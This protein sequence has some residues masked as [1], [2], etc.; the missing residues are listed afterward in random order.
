MMVLG[1]T[2]SPLSIVTE[3]VER[4]SLLTVLECEELSQKILRK[5]VEGIVAGMLHLHSE[6]IV[7]RGDFKLRFKLK[8]LDLAARNVLLTESYQPKMSDLGMSRVVQQEDSHMTTSTVGRI[9]L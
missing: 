1:L 6:G 4:G 7:H 3:Y 5:I 9:F 8:A 2:K